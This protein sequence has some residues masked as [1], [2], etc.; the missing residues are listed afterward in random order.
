[1]PP[2]NAAAREL[3]QVSAAFRS[4]AR[5]FQSLGWVLVAATSMNGTSPG[6]TPQRRK[7]RFTAEFRRHL[8]LQG[9]YMGTLRGLKPR[10]RS[11]VKRIRAAKGVSAALAAAQ[12][13]ATS[14]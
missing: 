7:P 5:A 8:K 11:H 4:L 13:I 3:H 14:R 12:R 9:A 1:M 2:R 10:Q 6:G